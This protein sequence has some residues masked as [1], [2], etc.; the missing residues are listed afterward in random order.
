MFFRRLSYLA[1]GDFQSA[2]ELGW[3]KADEEQAK[4]ATALAKARR[5]QLA[6]RSLVV[7]PGA[8]PF[9]DLPRDRRPE[10]SQRSSIDASKAPPPMSV[11]DMVNDHLTA[12]F[13]ETL[14]PLVES[15]K[16]SPNLNEVDEFKRRITS[17]LSATLDEIHAPPSRSSSSEAATQAPEP[18]K[19][20]LPSKEYVERTTACS[21]TS[22]RPSSTF[23]C[24]SPPSQ[25]RALVLGRC[26]DVV[27]MWL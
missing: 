10:R 8:M 26:L 12:H 16:R 7:I 14:L 19:L 20:K 21:N 17:D 24:H 9:P 25:R 23:R 22:G 13:V 11:N 3:D 4:A 1:Q 27:M 2:R 18:P 5:G 15:A 6:R